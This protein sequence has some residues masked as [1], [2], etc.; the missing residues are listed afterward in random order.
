MH[1]SCGQILAAFVALASVP[2]VV[3]A[4][5]T[6]MQSRSTIGQKP[7]RSSFLRRATASIFSRAASSSSTF[8]AVDYQ[9]YAASSIN[10][11]QKTYYN[12]TAGLWGST[13]SKTKK[14]SGDW[15]NSANT[16]TMLANYYGKFPSTAPWM[17]DLF[18]TVLVNAPA[19][20]FKGFLNDYYDDELWWCLA[21]IQVYDATQD[22]KYLDTA[23]SIYEDAKSVYGQT[24]CGGLWWDKSH[25][26]VN[27]VETSLYLTASAKLANRLPHKK[28]ST[29]AG[30]YFAQALK[31]YAFLIT[32]STTTLDSNTHLFN[33]GIS[34]ST[35]TNN[36]HT[37][38]TYNQGIILSG[39]VELTWSTKDASYTTLATQIA[40]SVIAN[41]TTNGILVEKACEPGKCDNNAAQFKGKLGV[42]GTEGEWGECGYADETN[43]KSIVNTD[44]DKDNMLGLVWSGG[45]SDPESLES[46]TSGLDTLVGAATVTA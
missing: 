46:T 3:D 36:H 27:T 30:Y 29:G 15:W 7:H 2:S 25:S 12:A 8:T 21:W 32:N 34:V 40:D 14:F 26:A 24:P 19:F 37:V 39:L 22:Q 6:S 42:F 10:A 43:A 44:D 16:L 38:Y 28:D 1:V 33:D 5:P 13:D 9:N 4:M 35:C 11:M 20:A 31:A 18:S 23:V 45:N 41:L 17:S